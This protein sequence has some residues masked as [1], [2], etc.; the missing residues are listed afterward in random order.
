MPLVLCALLLPAA[1]NAAAARP[2]AAQA[3]QAAPAT[4]PWLVWV[5]NGA[6]VACFVL[7]WRWLGQQPGPRELSLAVAPINTAAEDEW[8]RRA[9]AAEARADKAAALLKARLM[10]QMARWMMS[11]LVQR[12]LQ[13][14]AGL[15]A[16]QQQAEAEVAALE[17]RLEQLHAPLTDRVRA[18]EQRIAELEGQLAA[19][20]AQNRE[21]LRAAID[22]ARRKL[23]SERDGNRVD[24]N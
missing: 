24:W 2:G 23:Q 10:P 14:R 1:A 13:Q 18:Y 22:T 19:Q 20:N 7:W 12:L 8:Q 17:E 11:E 4:T 3:T 9:L 15:A 6:S 5:L 21:L 16:S